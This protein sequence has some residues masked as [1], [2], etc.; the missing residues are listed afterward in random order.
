[1]CA[2]ICARIGEGIGAGEADH[3]TFTQCDHPRRSCADV[4]CTNE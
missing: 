4:G 1:M 2:A 3:V